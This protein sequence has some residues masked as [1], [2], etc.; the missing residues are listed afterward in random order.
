MNEVPVKSSKYQWKIINAQKSFVVY[1]LTQS[2]KDSW[3][4]DIQ[5]C[6][7]TTQERLKTLKKEKESGSETVAAAPVWQQ[8]SRATRCHTCNSKFNFVR[9]K[10]HCRICGY[11]VCNECSKNRCVINAT[12][13]NKPARVCDACFK[14]REE[15]DRLESE[16]KGK[17]LDRSRDKN[18]STSAPGNRI[19]WTYSSSESSEYGVHIDS[20]SRKVSDSTRPMIIPPTPTSASTSSSF[21]SAPATPSSQLRQTFL[22]DKRSGTPRSQIRKIS[23]STGASSGGY[24]SGGYARSGSGSSWTESVASPDSATGTQDDILESWVWLPDA[25][26]GYVAAKLR[27]E[28]SD[29]SEMVFRT[30]DGEI[31]RR[32]RDEIGHLDKATKFGAENLS[33]CDEFSEG[34]IL[35]QFRQRY[36]RDIIYSYM[37]GIL[38]AIN[39]FKL[40]PI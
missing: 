25:E 3:I 15:E 27:E 14:K 6:I 20:P 31:M 37:G 35:D 33:D 9:R 39:P 13:N 4:N 38:V 30:A 19:G 18:L 12:I 29:K 21:Q 10:H 17:D 16:K 22:G 24:N 11:I 34:A 8:D 28:S 26:H 40:L 36:R 32:K 2:E 1:T 23:G 5:R 7:T